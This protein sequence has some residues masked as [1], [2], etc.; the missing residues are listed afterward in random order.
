MTHLLTVRDAA[1]ELGCTL[2]YILDLLY[3]GRLKGAA[4]VGRGWLI[5]A[6][7]IQ[8]VRKQQKTRRHKLKSIPHLSGELGCEVQS[9]TGED[10]RVDAMEAS[11]ASDVNRSGPEKGPI[12]GIQQQQQAASV[13]APSVS[14]R[15]S[16]S[17][18]PIRPGEMIL[19]C[20]RW[21]GWL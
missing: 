20:C 7:T 10:S 21:R 1:Q 8:E 17:V 14:K 6:E 19:Q 12:C 3:A 9:Q 4:K 15:R 13:L 18:F 5:P 16:G 2:K 11:E